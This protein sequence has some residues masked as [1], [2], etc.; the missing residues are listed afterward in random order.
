[1]SASREKNLRKQQRGEGSEK[2]QVRAVNEVQKKKARKK[3][4]TAAAIVVVVLLI[5]L[6]LVNSTLLYTGVPSVK[7]GDWKFTKADLDY[8]KYLVYQ[9][10]Y[11]NLYNTYGQYISYIIDTSKPLSEQQYSDTQTWDDYFRESAVDNLVQ[12]AALWDKGHAEGYPESDDFK[13]AADHAVDSMRAA[14]TEAGFKNFNTFLN[15]NIGKGVTEKTIRSMLEKVHYASDYSQKLVED[16]KNGFSKEELEEYYETV[17]NSY[18]KV[19]YASYYSAAASGSEEEEVDPEIAMNDAKAK[20]ELVAAASGDEDAF[21]QAVLDNCGED[22]LYK[23]YD[24][25]SIIS[26]STPQGLSEEW[27]EW[28]TDDGRSYGDTVVM[29]SDNG[30]YALMFIG[31]EDNDYQLADYHVITVSAEADEE[32]GE[33]SEEA[34][35][36]AKDLADDVAAQYSENPTVEN[37]ED[38]AVRYSQDAV[39]AATGGAYTGMSKDA[40]VSGLVNEYAF[41]EGRTEGDFS[42]IEDGSTYYL[43]RMD[44]YGD[45]YR[46]TISSEL[47]SQ[48]KYDELIDDLSEQYPV[49]TTLAYKLTK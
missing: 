31:I 9:T 17:R 35:R 27:R 2:R 46:E 43:I 42:V 20:A 13:A 29:E 48:D 44:G 6:V 15:M 32:T 23:Y 28:F 49:K 30:Y 38:L 41:E 12:I 1:M 40:F 36:A 14:A 37:F 19:T 7:A 5:F 34:I 8:E 18:D 24:K 33:I 39:S 45:N 26:K 3:I 16:W 11:Q 47:L 25:S 21:Y 22:E 4:A 10:T